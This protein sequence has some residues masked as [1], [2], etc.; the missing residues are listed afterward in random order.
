MAPWRRSPRSRPGSSP[1]YH[2]E[3][4]GPFNTVRCPS[5]RPRL[6]TGQAVFQSNLNYISLPFSLL[7]AWPHLW[8]AARQKGLVHFSRCSHLSGAVG[9]PSQQN[10]GGGKCPPQECQKS[11]AFSRLV[12][13]KCCNTGAHT[14]FD[15][16]D[17]PWQAHQAPPLAG[18]GKMPR[19][20]PAR[21][22]EHT[23]LVHLPLHLLK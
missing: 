3:C 4:L 11:Q 12:W 1:F 13:V 18:G 5:V 17:R 9:I 10:G 19:L 15:K 8:D 16:K 2:G 22:T 14:F 23:R 21:L 7:P 6:K 20:T